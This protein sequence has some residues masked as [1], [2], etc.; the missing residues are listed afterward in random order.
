MFLFNRAAAN[1]FMFCKEV[2]SSH[3][4][5]VDMQRLA[6]E[7]MCDS[8]CSEE[9][10]R[11][12]A[13]TVSVL[14]GLLG[15]DAP[16]HLVDVDLYGTLSD[17]HK[18][19]YGVRYRGDCSASEARSMVDSICRYEEIEAEERKRQLEI[20][21]RRSFGVSSTPTALELAFLQAAA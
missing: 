1:S 14:Q 10:L 4:W 15:V 6:F 5:A 20:E 16:C 11:R 19:H 2:S 21:A 9:S 3:A 12:Y 18:D 8:G 7:F 13:D 17:I